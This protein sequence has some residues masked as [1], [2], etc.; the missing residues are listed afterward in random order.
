MNELIL[1]KDEKKVGTVTVIPDSHTVFISTDIANVGLGG[2]V[3]VYEVGQDIK[4]SD[5]EVI[6]TVGFVKATLEVC[7]VY[8]DYAVCKAKKVEKKGGAVSAIAPIFAERSVITYDE[9]PVSEDDNLELSIKNP[10]ICVGDPVAR[11]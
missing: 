3:I 6:G 10:L 5:G 1:I 7:D 8:N 2:S 9:I 11:A 4:N